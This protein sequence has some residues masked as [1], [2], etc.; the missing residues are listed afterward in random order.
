MVKVSFDPRS[1]GRS[2]ISLTGTAP[3][4]T[5]S[6]YSILYLLGLFAAPAIDQMAG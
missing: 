1:V 3:A 6:C 2:R 5:F 4:K